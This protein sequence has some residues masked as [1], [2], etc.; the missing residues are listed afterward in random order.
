MRASKTIRRS[1]PSGAGA[2]GAR[3]LGVD[4]AE[5]AISLARS[6]YQGT[7][8]LSFQCWNAEGDEWAT[9]P[10]YDVISSRL[11]YTFIQEKEKFLKDVRDHLVPGGSFHVM[12]P[13]AV[14]PPPERRSAG[15]TAAEINELCHGWTAVKEH[16]RQKL[17]R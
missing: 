9:L 14:R 1:R 2:D 8:G 12:T 3:A 13:H 4:Y 10:L 15:I 5:T 16:D 17:S 7:S 11:S 6:R